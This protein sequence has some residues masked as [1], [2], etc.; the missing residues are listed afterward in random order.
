M[1]S[2]CHV[3]RM[4]SCIFHR[5]KFQSVKEE[6]KWKKY[7]CN[8]WPCITRRGQT[9]FWYDECVQVPL[10][11]LRQETKKKPNFFEHIS[12]RFG[13]K[14]VRPQPAT[15]LNLYIHDVGLCHRQAN[16]RIYQNRNHA[17]SKSYFQRNNPIIVSGDASKR[18]RLDLVRRYNPRVALVAMRWLNI[19]SHTFLPARAWH[20]IWNYVNLVFFFAQIFRCNFPLSKS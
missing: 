17:K 1:C 8:E 13:V 6:R 5:H 12:L 10:H 16:A 2:T 4:Y 15:H 14:K 18:W 11:L 7:E 3:T 9:G 19:A 20:R